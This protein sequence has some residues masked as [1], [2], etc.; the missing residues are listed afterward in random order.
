M[1]EYIKRGY[2]PKDDLICLFRIEPAKGISVEKAAESIAGESSIGTWTEVPEK[3]YMKNLGAKVFDIKGKYVKIAYPSALFEKG[4]APNILSAIAGNIFGM[5]I[6]KN[7]KLIDIS[8]PKSI[9]KGFQGP[10]L[11]IKGI[12]KIIKV[13][14]RPLIG[15]IIKPKIGLNPKDHAK[16]AYQAWIGG[17]DIVKSDENLASQEFNDFRERAALTLK[18]KEIAERN[19][20]E[21]KIYFENITAETG[22][23]IKRAK[24]VKSHGGKFVMLDILTSGFAA[25]ETLRNAN[26][27]LGI[28][29]HRAMH[30]AMTRNEKHGIS[31]MVLADFA[32]LIGVDSLHIGT[33]IGKMEGGI[34]QVEDIRG[35]IE[36]SYVSETNY[37]LRQKWYGIKPTMAVCS[38]GLHPGHIPYL[39]KHLGKDIII[40]AGGGIH[41]HP[42]GT[43]AGARAMRQAVDA[44]MQGITLREYAKNH[45]ELRIAI[46]EWGSV[47]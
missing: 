12:R 24:F 18:A 41:S 37:R 44:T 30:A 21:N 10:Y 8:F 31:M 34:E 5:K 36:N 26:L 19:T 16:V 17:C 3:A 25:L 9:I 15:T 35:E 20:R 22:E 42:N 27:K 7:L 4:N 38:G 39:V 28:H 46:D 11:G 29:A 1:S 2:K 43:I 40:Q 6:V 23:M 45:K 33:G 32:R 14:H 13:K 47:N